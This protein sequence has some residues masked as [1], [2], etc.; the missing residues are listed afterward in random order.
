MELDLISYELDEKTKE[1]IE[2]V[3]EKF[4]TKAEP[5]LVLIFDKAGRILACKGMDISD[6]YSEFISSI[7]SA[8]FFASEELTS[9]LDKNDEMKDVFYE[10]KNRV[11]LMARLEKDFLI[12]VISRKNLSL[13][14]IRL[15]FNHLVSDLNAVLK[16]LKEVEKKS[17]KIS[18]EELK[19]KL[20]Q[21]LGS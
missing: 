16:N 11:F 6:T 7:L 18:K 12:G 2:K 19:K 8:L 10:T 21:I 14:S 4:F 17:L 3:V 13:G 5:D 9:M 15:F 20:D 1:G